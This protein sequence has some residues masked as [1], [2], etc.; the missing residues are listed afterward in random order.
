MFIGQHL[1]PN[2]AA[3]PPPINYRTPWM[4]RNGDFG[5]YVFEII[6]FLETI[7]DDMTITVTLETK[8]SETA[9]SGA[10]ALASFTIGPAGST[11]TPIAVGTFDGKFEGALELVRVAVSIV[12]ASGDGRATDWIHARPNNISWGTN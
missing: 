1:A 6:D 8:N 9:D 3:V 11:Y 2:N 12:S 10:T 4:P 7:A 5:T